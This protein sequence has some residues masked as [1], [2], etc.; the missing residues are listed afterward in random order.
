MTLAEMS[1]LSYIEIFKG[2]LK[3]GIKAMLY[4]LTVVHVFVAIIFSYKISIIY[5]VLRLNDIVVSVS[6][7]S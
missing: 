1:S 4:H 6:T 2:L 3:Y 5:Q 7:T